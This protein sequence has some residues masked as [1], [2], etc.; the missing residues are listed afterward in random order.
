MLHSARLRSS[1]RLRSLQIMHAVGIMGKRLTFD[2]SEALP[3]HETYF[4]LAEA[5]MER[6]PFRRPDFDAMQLVK[7]VQGLSLPCLAS[8]LH[9]LIAVVC[10][11]EQTDTAGVPWIPDDQTAFVELCHVSD[12]QVLKAAAQAWA[13]LKLGPNGGAAP[14][15]LLDNDCT[16]CL[17]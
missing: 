15:S 14:K 5:C 13:K 12:T 17:G 9:T 2:R 8:V 7:R 16:R 3:A 1:R 4:E 10:S 11:Y 6:D